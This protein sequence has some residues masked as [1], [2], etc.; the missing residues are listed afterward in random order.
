MKKRLKEELRKLSTE[1]ISSR[2]LNDISALYEATKELYEKLAVLKYIEESLKTTE[3]KKPKNVIASK[4]E[5][6]ANSVLKANS[7]VPESNPHK[8]DIIVPGIDTIRDMV[9]EM[10]NATT[11]EEVLSQFTSKPEL[12]KNDKD[13]FMPKEVTTPPITEI[14]QTAKESQPRD[15]TVDLNDRLAFVKHLFNGSM[16]DYNRVL[17]QLRTID[18]EERSISFI[19]NMVK[20]DYN[21]WEGK[22][23]YELRFMGIIARKFS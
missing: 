5:S 8:E 7:S 14:R 20:P 10:P 1:I 13:L 19:E 4:F 21:H 18:T 9:S 12:M 15:I 2:N 3:A 17:S 23:D 22:E 6:M 16:E 11:I